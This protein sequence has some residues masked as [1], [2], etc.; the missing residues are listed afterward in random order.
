MNEPADTKVWLVPADGRRWRFDPGSVSLAFGYTGDFGHG[1]EEW[2]SLRGASDLD[3]WL[4]ERFG[5]MSAASDSEVLCSAKQ[6]RAAMTSAAR[7]AAVGRPL[8]AGD[9]DTINDWASRPALHP[10]LPGG[11]TAPTPP[12]P[13]QLLATIAHDGVRSL[14]GARGTIRE[15]TAEDCRL[16]F[17]DTSRP[18]NRR[19]CSMGRCGGRAKA[20]THYAR[21]TH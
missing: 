1:V 2:E 13:A 11:T 21:H 20:R 10:H 17:L 16:I 6:L 19:W 8:D 5:P 18:Q 9:V 4:S 15:C 14:S 3:A 12:T 7:A